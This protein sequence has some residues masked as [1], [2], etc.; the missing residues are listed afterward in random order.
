MRSRYGSPFV[1]VHRADLQLALLARAKELGVQFRLG[2]KVES[3]DFAET[4][5]ISDSG[6][7]FHGDLVVAADGL[8][9]RCRE[10]FLNKKDEPIPTGDLAYRI[11]LNLD[12]IQDEDLREW[13]AKPTVHFWIGPGAHAVGY[14]LRGGK[15]YNIV[16]LCPDTLPKNLS[17]QSGSVDEMKQLFTQWDPI[18]L[19]FLGLVK[20]VDKWRLMHHAEMEH[21]VNE[22][23]NLVFVGDAC[24]PMLPYLAQ[25]ANSSLED[26]AVLGGLLAHLKRKDQLPKLLH[27]YES[28]RKQRGEAIVRETFK[29]RQSFHMI[30]GPEQRQRD[31]IFRNRLG[32]DLGTEAFPSRW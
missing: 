24:H 8:W 12:D 13:V 4:T 1:D 22:A 17:R 15:M 6:K 16:L 20:T 5:V 21:W 10:I 25:G 19:R 23:S 31:E 7:S 29:Q 18:L 14:S 2:E 9:S 27:L 3:I 28:L 11:V 32:K 26:G 30:D